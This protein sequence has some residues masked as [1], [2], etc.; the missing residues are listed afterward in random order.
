MTATAT[1]PGQSAERSLA[2]RTQKL[3]L[4]YGTFQALFDIDLDIRQGII[5]AMIGPSGCG[6][7]TTLRMLAGREDISEGEIFIGNTLVNDLHPTDRNTAMVFQSYALYPHMSVA[8]NMGFALKLAGM[9]RAQVAK[10]VGDVADRRGE[11]GRGCVIGRIEL[12]LQ[13]VKASVTVT[14]QLP[15]VRL[16]GFCWVNVRMPLVHK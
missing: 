5:T 7:S 12:T 14:D 1:A 16:E 2:I 11:T 13:A 9:P 4:W 3:N 6:K 8:E 10:A 15:A